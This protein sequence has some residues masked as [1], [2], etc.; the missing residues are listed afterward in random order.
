MDVIRPARSADLPRLAALQ[1][2]LD[3]PSPELLASVAL[4]GS[5]LVAVPEPE[6]RPVGYVLVVGRGGESGEGDGDAHLAELV[7]HPEHRREGYGR[8]LVEAAIDGQAPGTRL[9]LLVA[10]DNDPARSL[11]ESL[12][13]RPVAYQPRFYEGE[14]GDGNEDGDEWTDAIVYA[15][16]A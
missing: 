6:S 8:A 11:Y 15:Y 12:G 9:T 1:S 14:N 13:F 16:D 5:C 2:E 10:V 3:A 4:A 7:V